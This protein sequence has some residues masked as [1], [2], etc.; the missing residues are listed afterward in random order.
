M[1]EAFSL[2]WSIASAMVIF[3]SPLESRK[4]IVWDTDARSPVPVIVSTPVNP[5]RSL[6]IQ[7]VMEFSPTI[8]SVRVRPDV[9]PVIVAGSF[10]S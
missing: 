10:L 6:V 2:I 7:I 4:V 5:G 1:V 3:P 8:W 9:P